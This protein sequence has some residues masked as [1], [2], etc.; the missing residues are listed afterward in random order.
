MCACLM[1]PKTDE[2][3][4]KKINAYNTTKE[5]MDVP[6]MGA[7]LFINNEACDSDLHQI[8]YNLVNMLDAFFTDAL[9]NMK[10]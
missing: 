10:P 2:P 5:L 4:Q 9:V 7:L 3:I 8:N 6:E 1:M